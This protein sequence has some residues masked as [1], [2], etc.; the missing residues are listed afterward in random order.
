MHLAKNQVYHARMKHIGVL[1]HFLRGFLEEE[2]IMPHKIKTVDNP[3]AMLTKV[4]IA[5]N[6]KYYLDFINILQI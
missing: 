3:A 6:F 2:M 5:I 1:Y 4:I